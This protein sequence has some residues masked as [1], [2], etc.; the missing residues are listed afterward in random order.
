MKWRLR[1]SLQGISEDVSSI[2]LEIEDRKGSIV[3]FA[4]Y[5]EDMRTT[6]QGVQNVI[7]KKLHIRCQAYKGLKACNIVS[8][9]GIGFETLQVGKAKTKDPQ[10]L[11]KSSRPYR[12]N[13]A[14]R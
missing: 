7:S 13:V 10:F 4:K 8:S 1:V 11:F 2:T 12:H 5:T 6:N 9:R 14:L 3:F